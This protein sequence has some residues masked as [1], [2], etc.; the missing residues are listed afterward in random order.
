MLPPCH[1]KKKK[2]SIKSGKDG[3]FSI[4]HNRMVSFYSSWI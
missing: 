4:D 3:L 2:K 1:A